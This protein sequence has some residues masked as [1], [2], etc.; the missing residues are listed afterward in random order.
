MSR[1][2]VRLPSTLHRQLTM[3]AS[4]EGISLNQYIVYALTRQSSQAYTIRQIAEADVEQQRATFDQLLESLGE[5]SDEEIANV[6]AKRDVV[7]PESEIE[8]EALSQFK[9]RIQEKQLAT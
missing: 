7:E 5:A 2:T 9:K 6:L 3:L 4:S 8:K 1:L